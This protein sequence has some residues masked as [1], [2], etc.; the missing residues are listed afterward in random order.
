MYKII[1]HV[2]NL[3]SHLITRM[4]NYIQTI[5]V[6]NIENVEN[7]KKALNEYFKLKKVIN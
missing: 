2:L 5:K 7:N 6:K 1:T 4:L 3:I